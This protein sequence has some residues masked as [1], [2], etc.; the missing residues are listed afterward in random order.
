MVRHVWWQC[1]LI[2]MLAGVMRLCPWSA[3]GQVCKQCCRNCAHTGQAKLECIRMQGGS[4]YVMLSRLLSESLPRKEGFSRKRLQREIPVHTRSSTPSC[5]SRH[6]QR[7]VERCWSS[8]LWRLHS[9]RNLGVCPSPMLN[10]MQ[11]TFY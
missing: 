7:A 4:C 2:H 1:C 5:C 8:P 9:L 6:H 10:S 11:T 3:T